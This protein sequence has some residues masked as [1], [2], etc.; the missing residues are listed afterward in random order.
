MTSIRLEP[1]ESNI[2]SES[3]KSEL[4]GWIRFGLLLISLFLVLRFGLSVAII[5]GESMAPTFQNGSLVLT[6]NLFYEPEYGDIIIYTDRHGFDVIKRIIG[7]PGDQVEIIKSVVHVNGQPLSEEYTQGLADSMDA[8]V[9]P[10][11]S[12]FVLGD[13]RSPGESFDSRSPEVGSISA[14]SIKG[15]M[16]VSLNPFHIGNSIK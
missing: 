6:N 3:T 4:W 16:M 10:Q 14:A 11:S 15:E 1:A 13:H 7:L 5:S 2:K 12:Y 9:V 8:L